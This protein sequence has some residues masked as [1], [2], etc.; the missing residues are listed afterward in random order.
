MN[1]KEFLAQNEIE[2]NGIVRISPHSAVVS[3]AAPLTLPLNSK[4][5]Y[6]WIPVPNLPM[7]TVTRTIQTGRH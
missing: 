1:F 4:G 6:Q 2:D 5:Q 3:P 7:T